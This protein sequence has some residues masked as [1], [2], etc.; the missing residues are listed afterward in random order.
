MGNV[1]LVMKDFGLD[2]GFTKTLISGKDFI[3]LEADNK[4]KVRKDIDLAKKKGVLVIVNVK[5][6]D[7]LRYLI[8][9]TKVDIILGIEKINPKDNVHFVRG[10]LDQIVCK[11]AVKHEKI[12]GFSFYDILKSKPGFERAK[13]LN[14][15]RFNLKLCKK[16]GVKIYFGNFSKSAMQMRAPKELRAILKVLNCTKNALEI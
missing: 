1:N 15:I 5:D 4:N 12:I 3:I 13:L 11:L 7:T 10:G 2:L 9:K 8:E 16:F 6:E 14:R